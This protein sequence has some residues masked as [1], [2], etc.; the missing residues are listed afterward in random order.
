MTLM[1]D[2]LEMCACALRTCVPSYTG[3][4]ARL[5]FMFR[6]KPTGSHVTRG[7]V[8]A[9]LSQEARS[10]AIGHMA[11]SELTSAGKRGLEP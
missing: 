9:H 4:P 1:S 2:A 6:P 10:G 11:A 8:R 3:R 5:F 7:S